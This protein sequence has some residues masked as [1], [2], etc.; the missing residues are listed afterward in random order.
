MSGYPGAEKERR[1]ALPDL[2]SVVRSIFER[3][4]MRAGHAVLLAESLAQGSPR[5]VRDSGG[6]LLI[7]GSNSRGQIAG[8]FAMR[9]ALERA[10]VVN[11]AVA[12]V[13]GWRRRVRRHPPASATRRCAAGFAQRKSPARNRSPDRA[14]SA[15]Y[16]AAREKCV[17][18][19]YTG[20]WPGGQNG[21]LRQAP[22]G[23][24]K[25]H[26]C[27]GN[28]IGK[29]LS[30]CV[31]VPRTARTGGFWAAKPLPGRKNRASTVYSEAA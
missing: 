2:E 30:R 4:G 26:R 3:C 25:A 17:G 20:S 19:P 11:V 24:P 28:G 12:A 5:V 31:P 14:A 7:D 16:L 10:R 13:R 21:N 9:A 8:A 6:A 15:G 29:G 22:S 1:I 23:C 27:L 18:I